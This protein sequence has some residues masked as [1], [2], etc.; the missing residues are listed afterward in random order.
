MQL[1]VGIDKVFEIDSKTSIYETLKKNKL[2]IISPCGGKGTCGKCK[3]KIIKGE[4]N[5]NNYGKLLAAEK[6]NKIVLA[7]QTF[8]LG[9]LE[10]EIPKESVLV[11]G[12]QIATSRYKDLTLY[13]ETYG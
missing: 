4:Y 9:D 10:I 1:K 3:V 13:L 8:V 6:E 5:C 2:F 7:C 11:V 12:E